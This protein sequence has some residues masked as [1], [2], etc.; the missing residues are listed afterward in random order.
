MQDCGAQ[1]PYQWQWV[2][3]CLGNGLDTPTAGGTRRLPARTVGGRI[4]EKRE[5][6]LGG[7]KGE[8]GRCHH[9]YTSTRNTRPPPASP[10]PYHSTKGKRKNQKGKNSNSMRGIAFQAIITRRNGW[11]NCIDTFE[12]YRELS[13]PSTSRGSSGRLESR[14]RT[15]DNFSAEGSDTVVSAV[16]AE[17]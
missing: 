12:S 15:R 2:C 11:G 13:M 7:W 3:F 6:D 5:E 4:E 14:Q 10:S 9:I 8:D 17:T 16:A 1:R